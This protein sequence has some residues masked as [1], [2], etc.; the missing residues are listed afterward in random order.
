[1]VVTELFQLG[2]GLWRN[3]SRGAIAQDGAVRI[4][5]DFL[6]AFFDTG[7][8]H[9]DCVEDMPL[10]EILRST[11]INHHGIAV[12]QTHR[13]TRAQWL[14]AHHRVPQFS[15]NQG[16]Q[17]NSQSTPEKEMIQD[18]FL[19]LIHSV[20]HGHRQRAQQGT[21]AHYPTSIQVCVK[22]NCGMQSG[23]IIIIVFACLVMLA[24][25][26]ASAGK[27][28]QTQAQLKATR[29]RIAQVKKQIQSGHAKHN[30]T[31]QALAAVEQ[32]IGHIAHHLHD[33]DDQITLHKR[34]I[35]KLQAKLARQKRQLHDQLATLDK[36]IRAVYRTGQQ[37]KLRLLL[38]QDDPAKLGRLL[39]YYSYYADAQS[40]AIESA[41][42]H[43]SKL[44]KTRSDLKNQKAILASDRDQ[45]SKLLQG[46]RDSQA[47]R[48]Q[49][50]AKIE[51]QI[52]NKGRDLKQLKSSAAQLREL[53]EAL[54]NQLKDIPS[55][56]GQTAFAT[57]KGKLA[58]PVHGLA[59]KS[60]GQ[61]K[62]GGHL[63][64][65]G[66]WL[67]ASPGTAVHAVGP[68]RVVYVGWM[69]RYGLIVVLDHGHDYYTVYGHN[70]SVYVREGSWVVAG[71]TIAA[72]GKS[73]GHKISG[74]YFEIRHGSTP[75]RPSTWLK[76]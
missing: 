9:I 5:A 68:G 70:Q 30:A 59:I 65:H 3:R 28:Q 62:A 4:L 60:F 43:I 50:L 40:H 12:D 71:Q 74:V 23:R 52:Q 55:G 75:L 31:Q 53:I 57:R 11:H 16:K 37:S 69:H 49:T 17:Y 24:C 66:V 73:G 72:A 39:V 29:A 38:S 6:A 26:P 36:Q 10:L 54:N 64:W 20:S 56:A 15:C 58:P 7:Q 33:L 46:L 27:L 25:M 35:N 44:Q 2:A 61:S 48:K 47:S 21:A 22:Y 1:M 18:K 45:Q 8:R 32:K 42:R 13:V 67:K 19:Y 63:R 14:G 34:A 41:R 76:S 51:S